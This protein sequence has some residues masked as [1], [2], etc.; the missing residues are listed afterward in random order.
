[1]FTPDQSF[2]AGLAGYSVEAV[3]SVDPYL[4]HHVQVLCNSCSGVLRPTYGKR[5]S[6]LKA[7][8]T[9]TAQC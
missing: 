6:S 8:L 3:L 5:I 7:V 2:D 9:T 1:M 4:N